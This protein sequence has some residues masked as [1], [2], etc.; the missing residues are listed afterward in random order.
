MTVS[1][2]HDRVL[3]LRWGSRFPSLKRPVFPACHGNLLSDLGPAT[4]SQPML[5]SSCE[6][7]NDK[8][9]ML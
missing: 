6:D 5:H 4:H 2:I 3:W 9:R 7:K 1:F 8:G